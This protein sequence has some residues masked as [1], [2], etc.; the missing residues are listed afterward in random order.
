YYAKAGGKYLSFL[1]G[2]PIKKIKPQEL[3]GVIRKIEERG[4]IEIAH[5]TYRR[6][7]TSVQVRHSDREN[8]A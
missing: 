4:A 1:G 7:G 6:C 8:R 3:L 5:K 2:L